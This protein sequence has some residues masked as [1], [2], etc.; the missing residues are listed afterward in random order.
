MAIKCKPFS[1]ITVESGTQLKTVYI[2]S[3]PHDL[4]Y[5]KTLSSSKK[6]K[7]EDLWQTFPSS[8]GWPKASFS[9]LTASHNC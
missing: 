4:N 9:S 2:C 6:K 1:E 3:A 8:C 7:K 5:V